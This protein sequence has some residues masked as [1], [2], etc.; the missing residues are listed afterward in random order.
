MK[1]YETIVEDIKKK[2]ISGDLV[3]GDKLPSIKDMTKIYQVS[4]ITVRNSLSILSNEGYI[5]TKERSGCFVKR[6][7]NDK[8]FLNFNELT[9]IKDPILSIKTLGI[10]QIFDF[11]DI[12]EFD[13]KQKRRLQT[14]KLR[15]TFNSYLDAPVA[16]DIKFLI[17]HFKG[18]IKKFLYHDPFENLDKF[19][20]KEIAKTLEIRIIEPT[21]DIMDNLKV[22][23]D[24]PVFYFKQKYYNNSKQLILVG[25]TYA[26]SDSVQITA[27]SKLT[28]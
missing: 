21:Q 13:N 15:R 22:S 7:E 9:N 18:D 24:T 27:S 23:I 14:I 3:A 11:N 10:S 16:Y 6:S 19:L 2:I 5:I 25:K 4:S 17:H 26:I 20:E 8:F 12:D 28:E 1:E